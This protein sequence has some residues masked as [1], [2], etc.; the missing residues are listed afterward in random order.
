MDINSLSIADVIGL[1]TLFVALIATVAAIS[2]TTS[3]SLRRGLF[4]AL[5]VVVFCSAMLLWRVS[6]KSE[7]GHNEPTTLPRQDQAQAKIL[8]TIS[9]GITAVPTPSLARSAPPIYETDRI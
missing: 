5:L 7:V 6:V 9:R 1:V 4:V 8:P 3:T 2:V